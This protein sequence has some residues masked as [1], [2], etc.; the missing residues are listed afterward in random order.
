LS[1][2][3][4]KS[5]DDQEL[6]LRSRAR[7]ALAGFRFTDEQKLTVWQAFQEFPE[8][9]EREI[10]EIREGSTDK[11][12]PMLLWRLE[13]GWHREPD[14]EHVARSPRKTGWRWVR[15][16]DGQSGTYVEDPEGID[17]LPPHYDLTTHASRPG[18]D[19]ADDDPE[20]LTYDQWRRQ[21]DG[22]D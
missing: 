19:S 9:V 16:A 14:F 15:G 18:A 6:E 22:S 1:K 21:T 13:Q 8:G 10:R 7:E 20:L 4:G 3:R 2:Q 5:V 17:P 11:P 12:E